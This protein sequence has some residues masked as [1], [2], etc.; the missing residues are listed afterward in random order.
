MYEYEMNSNFIEL[1]LQIGDLYIKYE[2]V[3]YGWP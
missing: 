1:V 3:V 2:R